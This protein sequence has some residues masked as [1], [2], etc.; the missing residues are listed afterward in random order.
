MCHPVFLREKALAKQT[1]QSRH[2]RPR[3]F[4]MR[5]NAQNMSVVWER[6]GS[7]RS[8]LFLALLVRRVS[9]PACHL[10]VPTWVIQLAD[11]VRETGKV[12]WMHILFAPS[13]G[14]VPYRVS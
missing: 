10:H 9:Q 13:K 5:R 11:A 6:H 1:E 3:V 12:G 4:A 8:L 14:T 2:Q 7:S